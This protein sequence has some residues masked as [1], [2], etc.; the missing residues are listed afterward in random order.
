M[1]SPNPYTSSI[2]LVWR[3][4]L[5][6]RSCTHGSAASLRVINT[7][8]ECCWEARCHRAPYCV[9][10][11]AR[12]RSAFIPDLLY[13]NKSTRHPL[14]ITTHYQHSTG[15]SWSTLFS[16]IPLE[17]YR[18]VP[19][20]AP[21]QLSSRSHIG[22]AN[23]KHFFSWPIYPLA[24]CVEVGGW[25]LGDHKTFYPCVKSIC[26]PKCCCRH[27]VNASRPSSLFYCSECCECYWCAGRLV[28]DG[29][30]GMHNVTWGKAHSPFLPFSRH[31]PEWLWIH[32]KS[33]INIT[34]L[35]S[36]GV[37]TAALKQA[38]WFDKRYL[39]MHFKIQAN[40]R[41][42]LFY[43]PHSWRVF[44]LECRDVRHQRDTSSVKVKG[45]VGAECTQR[46]LV[47]QVSD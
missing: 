32:L 9:N 16:P 4:L 28:I 23:I 45:K 13:P 1:Q 24:K 27:T 29:L 34:S 2:L 41:L 8:H 19:P 22:R 21:V 38:A 35:K 39:Y 30:T 25:V 14:M 17:D 31:H 36:R 44:P 47:S 37:Q 46:Y 15:P 12:F 26:L 18:R 3:Q 10:L 11:L 7:L 20:A 6:T 43:F 33:I 40:D 5:T 42:L